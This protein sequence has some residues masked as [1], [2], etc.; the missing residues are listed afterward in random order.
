MKR[1]AM[2]TYAVTGLAVAG[3]VALA[4]PPVIAAVTSSPHSQ[5]TAAGAPKATLH[6]TTSPTPDPDRVIWLGDGISVKVSDLPKGCTTYSKIQ[7]FDVNGHSYGRLVGDAADR[8]PSDGATG[9]VNRDTAG[10]IVGY[11]AAPGDNTWS[12]G[13][14]LCTNGLMLGRYN[15]VGTDPG[16]HALQP[17]ETM[18][19]RP[20]MNAEWVPAG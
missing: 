9:T 17:G 6:P 2:I 10:N 3:L 13:D 14:R 11:T 5:S 18:V 16:D 20:D 4:A 7:I 19:I 1:S 15:H 12:I 8:G